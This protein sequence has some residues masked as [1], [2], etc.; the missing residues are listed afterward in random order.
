MMQEPEVRRFDLN[1]LVALDALLEE[2]NVSKAAARLGL[3]QPAMSRALGRLRKSFGDQLLVR[4]QNGYVPTS[5]AEALIAPVRRVLQD[6]RALLEPGQFDAAT[7]RAQFRILSNEHCAFVLMPDLMGAIRA[8]APGIDIEV[9]RIDGDAF[10]QLANGDADL[11]VGRLPPTARAG[12]LVELLFEDSYVCALRKD[13]PALKDGL[14][15]KSYCAH[16]HC[17]IDT[18]GFLAGDIDAAL[19]ALGKKRRIAFRTPDF[20]T[21]LFIAASSDLIQTAPRSLASQLSTGTGLA[22]AELPLKIAPVPIGQ[23]WH[24]RHQTDPGHAWLRAQVKQNA[25]GTIA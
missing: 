7:A 9:A 10:D 6:S 18:S 8:Q 12:H 21:A 20:V 11:L 23:I 2:R 15:L 19:T 5:R 4:G 1:L 24:E 25:L 3:S 16:P 13:H 14:T 17:A 22:L